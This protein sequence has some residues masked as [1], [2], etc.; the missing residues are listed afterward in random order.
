MRPHC[1]E[2][3]FSVIN[4]KGVDTFGFEVFNQIIGGDILDSSSACI[5]NFTHPDFILGAKH[6]C[7]FFH[8][9]MA[10]KACRAIPMGLKPCN[11][12][13]WPWVDKPLLTS[14]ISLDCG[15]NH[16]PISPLFFSIHLVPSV[17]SLIVAQ[18]VST[19][20]PLDSQAV[21]NSKGS[22]GI[23]HGMPSRTVDDK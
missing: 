19:N 8:K 16:Q 18:G 20:L 7:D 1:I 10:Q 15:Q 6:F 4:K 9:I 14:R 11:Q 17:D 2:Q 22:H 21:G 23:F 3:F 12:F 13:F 5:V